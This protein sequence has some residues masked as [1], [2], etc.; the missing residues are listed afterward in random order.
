[1]QNWKNLRRWRRRSS[2][3]SENPGS[4]NPLVTQ[5]GRYTTASNSTC[6]GQMMR[7]NTGS[8]VVLVPIS[9]HCL[10]RIYWQGPCLKLFFWMNLL[11]YGQRNWMDTPMEMRV[12]LK[13]NVSTVNQLKFWMKS[14]VSCNVIRTWHYSWP[15]NLV[16]NFWGSFCCWTTGYDVDVKWKMPCWRVFWKT[17]TRMIASAL[18]I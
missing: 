4:A 17:E 8:N 6:M 16:T 3:S 10:Q 13:L 18:Y 14:S 15:I 7:L 1:M 9:Y 5:L 12:F 2:H 11:G